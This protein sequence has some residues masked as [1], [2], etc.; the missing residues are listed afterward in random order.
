[1]TTQSH[2]SPAGL[3]V[4]PNGQALTAEALT[5]MQRW[6]LS[7]CCRYGDVCASK[8]NRTCR[9]LQRRGLVYLA[10]ERGCFGFWQPT[11]NGRA[12]GDELLRAESA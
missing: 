10:W 3:P 8:A 12:V 6:Y 4:Q 7:L 1:M 11:T 5:P 2:V 9:A